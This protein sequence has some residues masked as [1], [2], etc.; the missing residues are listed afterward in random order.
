MICEHL[1]AIE[2]AIAARRIQETF[3]GRPWSLRCRE[4][5]YFDCFICLASVRKLFD[6]ADCVVD[7]AHRGTHDGEERGLFCETCEDGIM[8]YYE[9]RPGKETF[10]A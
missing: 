4:W 8:G 3:R 2:A 1:K 7:H 5:V 6:L 10:P 9:P